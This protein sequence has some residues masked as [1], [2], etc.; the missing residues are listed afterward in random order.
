V[1]HGD[2]KTVVL[3]ALAANL[4]IALAKFAA[5]A[6]TRSSAMLSEAIHSLVD[7][8]NQA[9]LLYGIKRSSRPADALH[10]FGDLREIYFWSFVVAV[11]L[12]SMGAGVS[13]YEGIAKLH[14]PHPIKDFW[15]N[16]AVLGVALALESVSAWKAI[17]TFAPTIG[18]RGWLA[19]VRASKDAALFA[20]LLEDLAA[21]SGLLIALVALL[22]VQF[23]GWQ[24]ADAIASIAIGLLLGAVAA[25][26]SIEIKGLLVGE[27]A[28]P[29]VIAGIEAI[30]RGKVGPDGPL[31]AINEIRT[32]HLGAQDILVA[33]SVD[34]IDGITA[35]RVEA[36][37]SQLERAIKSKFPEVRRLYIE[38]QSI[39]GH[40]AAAVAPVAAAAVSETESGAE[41]VEA[42][43]TRKAKK[44][45]KREK[46]VEG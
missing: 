13:V 36:V 29:Q 12:F 41:A 45:A 28:N 14:N 19:A 42:A 32:M 33:A 4:G 31:I 46:K 16:Y 20:V 6:W 5:T 23:L 10:P 40:E 34:A 43:P 38:T 11:L 25:F 27:A 30:L 22:C 24:R 35:G 1:S 26:M 37:T 44:R 8:S 9:L 15:V 3:V 21:V 7:T 39:A 17:S 2:S 18:P